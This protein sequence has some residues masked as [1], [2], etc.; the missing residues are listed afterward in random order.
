MRP[1]EEWALPH[2]LFPPP[3]S[4]VAGPGPAV[5]NTESQAPLQTSCTSICIARITL[6]D[7]CAQASVRSTGWF[8]HSLRVVYLQCLFYWRGHL[9]NDPLLVFQ[10][11]GKVEISLNLIES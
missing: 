6:G 4:V 5:R 11:V 8:S 1:W 10:W 7:S 9:N 3:Q 2:P